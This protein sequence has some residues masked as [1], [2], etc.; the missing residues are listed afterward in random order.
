MSDHKNWCAGGPMKGTL[1]MVRSIRTRRAAT[2]AAIVLA[3]TL[4]VSG[5]GGQDPNAAAV[6]NGQVISE[7]AVEEVTRDLAPLNAAGQDITKESVLIVLVLRPLVMEAAQRAGTMVSES[8]ARTALGAGIA[9][10]SPATVEFAQTSLLSRR[11][12]QD[13]L[14]KVADAFKTASVTVNPRYG[15]IDPQGASSR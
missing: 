4:G 9:H 14:A 12:P 10:P 5:C 8:E 1:V 11:L 6:V 15:A 13:E 7:R 2:A 3:A